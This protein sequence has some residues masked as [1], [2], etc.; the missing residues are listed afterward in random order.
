VSV[1]R[2][3]I[4][5]KQAWEHFTR[6]GDIDG[7]VR[8]IISQSWVRCAKNCLDPKTLT[9][10]P[11]LPEKELK[12]RLELSKRLLKVSRPIMQELDELVEGTGYLTLLTDKEGV[13]L[14]LMCNKALRDAVLAKNLVL[15]GIWSEE[16]AGTSAIALA[17][18]F[19]KPIQIIGEEHF[20]ESDHILTCSASPIFDHQGNLLGI[21][22]MSGPR[23]KAY[24][25]TLGM[26]VAASKAITKQLHIEE[27][28]RK[29]RLANQYLRTIIE[30]I[31]EGVVSVDRY[32]KIMEINS[33]GAKILLTTIADARGKNIKDIMD[34]H[35]FLIT[36][37]DNRKPITDVETVIDTER[38]TIHCLAS[39]KMV[40][41]E[42][43]HLAGAVA[44]LKGIKRIHKVVNKFT[45]A[46][47]RFTFDDIIGHNALFLR[48]IHLAQV[49]AKGKSTVLIFGES[50]T[51]K[52]LFAQ[53][54][55]N[56][57]QYGQPF[58]AINCSAIP[59]TLIESELFGYEDGAFTGASKHGRPGKFELANGGTVF[60]DEIGEM[61]L[62]TQVTL[63]RVL[64]ERCVQRIG[65]I[66]TIPIDVRVIAATNKNLEE[67]VAKGAFRQD[68][69][70]RLNVF[71]IE[72]PPLRE[73]KTDIPVLIEYFVNTIATRFEKSLR[74]ISD[75]TIEELQRYS[76][77]GNV[78]Q[79][80]NYIE[81]AVNF[82][83]NGQIDEYYLTDYLHKKL[84]NNLDMNI[85]KKNEPKIINIHEIEKENLMDALSTYKER[86]KAAEA[87]GISR[88]TL[89]RKLK[90]FGLEDSFKI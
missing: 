64:Q 27:D 77:P 90:K 23:E 83:E 79:L 69:F 87:L 43:G 72:I 45:G 41:L 89:Y 26:V 74:K 47:A 29:I 15:G 68:L 38:G 36:E 21:L 84:K 30:S 60:L 35:P 22:N 37:M 46:E 73:R 11:V 20:Y 76:W 1:E 82:A 53:A 86:K 13:I 2:N 65:G 34:G 61:P 75:G 44:T 12:K 17:I 9:K 28:N 58:V 24:P 8:S 31:S 88:S 49:A 6:T 25:H 19:I 14:E 85:N 39:I 16:K 4:A 71:Q 50:G 10:V 52:E 42:E 54:I 32:G 66:R 56:Y 80:E 63:L 62:K 5:I 7:S 3:F 40:S 81:R 48:A 78:R 67:E 51:G 55:H 18:R 57:C 59:E 33:E 70:Y